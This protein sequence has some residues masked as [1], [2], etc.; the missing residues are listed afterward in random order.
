MYTWA[1]KWTVYLCGSECVRVHVKVNAFGLFVCAAFKFCLNYQR[2]TEF[3][4]LCEIVSLCHP[5]MEC[6]EDLSLSLSPPV[7]EP[8]AASPE[9]PVPVATFAA[10]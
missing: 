3:R 9:I 4:K 8:P 7:E 5:R 2:R 1:S 6:Y 10:I